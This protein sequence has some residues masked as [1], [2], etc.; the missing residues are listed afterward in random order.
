MDDCRISVSGECEASALS[1]IMFQLDWEQLHPALQ[2]YQADCTYGETSRLR[3]PSKSSKQDVACD[4][5]LANRLTKDRRYLKT[6]NQTFPG[7]FVLRCF[8]HTAS[9]SGIVALT[10]TPAIKSRRLRAHVLAPN[11]NQEELMKLQLL[12]ALVALLPTSLLAAEAISVEATFVE[13]KARRTLPHDI[14]QAQKLRDVD[15]V[16]APRRITPSGRAAQFEITRQF[17]AASLAPS[18]HPLIPT[19]VVL[20]VTPHA[21]GSAVTYTARFTMRVL[22]S[23]TGVGVPPISTFTTREL[24]AS[25]TSKPGEEVWLD[26]PARDGKAATVRLVFRRTDA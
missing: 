19:G 15:V 16:I 8:K 10:K 17:H 6:D 23:V 9:L 13:G 11:H 2:K 22:D 12:C 26:L 3:P 5:W 25:G 24:Y 18:K 14:K 7:I 20:H 4:Y 21:A 1:G